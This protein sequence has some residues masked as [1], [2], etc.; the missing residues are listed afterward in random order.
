VRATRG[1]EWWVAG[2]STTDERNMAAF[3][4]LSLARETAASA[5]GGNDTPETVGRCFQW[6]RLVV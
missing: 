4:V 6:R 1:R 2:K 3:P 5:R